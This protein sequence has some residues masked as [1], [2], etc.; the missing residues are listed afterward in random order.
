MDKNDLQK[1]L[2]IS[3]FCISTISAVGSQCCRRVSEREVCRVNDW[4]YQMGENNNMRSL[5]TLTVLCSNAD[6]LLSLHQPWKRNQWAPFIAVSAR[7]QDAKMEGEIWLIIAAHM[8]NH[9]KG[10]SL[11]NWQLQCLIISY[12]EMFCA[13]FLVLLDVLWR[14]ATWDIIKN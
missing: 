13:P 8:P 6:R 14:R 3:T 7:V 10:K 2:L 11:H 5:F 9:L 1:T 4:L 12:F